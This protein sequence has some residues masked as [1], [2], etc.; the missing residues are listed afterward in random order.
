MRERAEQLLAEG[1]RALSGELGVR[2][3]LALLHELEVHQ[4]E[5][6]LQNEELR[7]VQV[8]QQLSMERYSDLFEFAPVGYVSLTPDAKILQV[9]L[10]AANLLGVGRRD[11][12][13]TS[14]G[15]FVAPGDSSIFS[16]FLR[17][18]VV[19]QV[20]ESIELRL[21]AT[22][23]E[24]FW[25]RIEIVTRQTPEDG[26]LILQAAMSDI[27]DQKRGHL[28]LERLNEELEHRVSQRTEQLTWTNRELLSEVNRRREAEAALRD[29]EESLERRV[30]ERT[31]ELASLLAISRDISST[32]D[33]GRIL[34]I[35]LEELQALVDYQGCG[36]FLLHG[37]L[38]TLVAYR[39]PQSRYDLLQSQTMLEQAPLLGHVVA[40]QA[41][42]F[43]ADMAADTDLSREWRETAGALQRHLLGDARSW[44]G[45][46]LIAK[47]RVIGV[48]RLDHR[49]P[50]HFDEQ[51]ASLTLTLANQTAVAIENAQLYARAQNVAAV[52][53][54]Q[55]LARELHDSVA[56]TFYS[57]SLSTHAATA[58]IG[59]DP[60][61]A[62][63]HL[64]HVLELANSGLT[65]MK[66][67]IFDLQAESIRREGVVAALRRQLSAI[68]AR[69]DLA[70]DAD[71]GMEPDA[72][73]ET[74]ETVYA[75]AR[76]ALQ[77][78]VRHA[79]AS[80]LGVLLRSDEDAIRLEVRDNGA[81]FEP[82][83]VGVNSLGLRSMRERA[84]GIGGHFEI[85]SEP[86]KGTVVRASFPVRN[87]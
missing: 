85:E 42:V 71:L 69:D 11:L 64:G 73:L 7:R 57:I 79:G 55:R 80:R 19:P 54:R 45:V 27:D 52:E 39:G 87:D 31:K 20:S 84:A 62:V 8:E 81:G 75:V 58:Q 76:E 4:V 36:I 49:D 70:V 1:G 35:I 61:K 38:L 15:A 6:E 59:K 21:Q 9:N 83:R 86:G 2:D 53:E 24:P 50:G 25:V 14:F 66:A 60:E 68:T 48:F 77:N 40:G 22:D 74:K 43:V 46:P 29:R 17:R 32:L 18:L 47:G 3:A 82:S 67:L 65:E 12:I 63:R 26:S 10:A 23:R 51:H 78:V 44:L 13:G 28:L 16:A 30:A 41:P 56:Q 33:I 34:D 37:E 5:L 72:P